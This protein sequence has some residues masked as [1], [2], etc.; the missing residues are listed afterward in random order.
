MRVRMWLGAVLLVG[1]STAF[2]KREAP[3]SA[4]D[5]MTAQ[6]GF[7]DVHV[8]AMSARVLVGV[9]A[10]D[11]PMLMV[12]ALP[13]ALGSNDVGLDRAQAGEPKLVEFRRLGAK[14]LL[15][16]RN[17][18]F[19]ADSVVSDEVMSAR[20][21]FAESVL[22]SGDLLNDDPEQGPWLVDMSSLIASDQ[23]GVIDRLASVQQGQYVLDAD[24]SG[25]LTTAAKS[26]PD[27]AEFEALLT[28]SGSGSGAF[29]QQAVAD[30]KSITLRQQLSFV[31]LPDAGFNRRAFHPASGGWSVGGVDFAQPLN[32]DLDVRWQ[33]RFRLQ[34]NDPTAARSTVVKPIVF[35][36]DRGTPE[37]VRSALLEGARWW[38]QAFDAAGFIDAFKV[39]LAPAGMDL[40]DVRY[41]AITWTH[42]ATRGWSYGGGIV[43]PRSGEIIKGFV[44]LGSQRVRQDLLIAEGLL[45]AHAPD[46]DPALQQQALDLA[47]AR[48]RQLAAHE[49]GHALGFAHNFAASRT[50]NGS[51]LDYPHPIITLDGEGRV[52]LAKPYA[53]GIGDWDTFVV[54][55]AYSEFAPA[56]TATALA[57]LRHD[58]A[59]QGYRY[60]S[61]ADA[62]APGDA[63]PDGVLWDVGS[64]PVASFDHL[65]QV[66]AAA[67]SRFAAGA[68]PADRQ[69]GELERRL[70]PIHLLHRYQ[71]EAVARLIGGAEYDYGLGGDATLGT[72]AVAAPRQHAA[73]QALSRALAVDTLALPASVRA[74]LTPPSTEYSRTPEYFTTQT[75]P[76]FDEAAATAAAT[77]L[78]T[79][80]AFAPQRLNR[81]AWQ[82][83]REPMMPS[84]REVF[85]VLVASP[86][87]EAGRTNM[88]VRSTRNWVLLDAALNL[89]AGSQLHATVDAEWRGR[90]R[91]FAAELGAMPA[92]NIDAGEGARLIV[93]YLDAPE[94]VK[95]RPLP[96]IPP[97]AP[98]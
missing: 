27:N 18:K 80:F 87:R 13:G 68:L 89:L 63:H 14:L 6:T 21:A 93:R 85:D 75:G 1:L 24:R 98:I 23:H 15:V 45:A 81:L 92:T 42:R 70:V 71:T 77:A 8:D 40:A 60:V 58:I 83:S 31:R 17:M 95:L 97:G 35:Y 41:N 19:I 37:P 47:L 11:A 96:T 33:A 30:A 86:W 90:L 4:T 3:P 28:F 64:D 44:N 57:T 38:T 78:V 34:K 20:D 62:R 43:D 74:A 48:L 69:S 2:A 22:W 46:A 26:Y 66:R 73:L 53:I 36:L 54:A 5:G 82:Q 61:D 16:Q 49:V 76:L 94:T 88:R 29:V 10:L 39:E 9:H 32:R 12:T 50:G 51:V 79:Q 55:H 52:Q 56:Q 25:V 91:A 7:I 65:L 84:L 67:L 59:A 72:H